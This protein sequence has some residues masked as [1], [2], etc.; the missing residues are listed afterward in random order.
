MSNNIDASQWTTF[1]KVMYGGF[2]YSSFCLPS[3]FFKIIVAILFPPLGELVNI[4]E[5]TITDSFPFI[6]WASVKKLC[7]Y[8]TL[9]TI[10]YSIVLTTLFYIPGLIYTLS[11]IVK[12]EHNLNY[13]IHGQTIYESTD[14]YGSPIRI[15]K[16]TINGVTYIKEI[17]TNGIRTIFQ[18]TT[19][20]I[21]NAENDSINNISKTGADAIKNLN[22]LGGDIAGGFEKAGE[23][24]SQIGNLF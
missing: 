8:E 24:I 20:D 10:V 13:D 7:T 12:K 22:S 11:N 23:G 15:T 16:T 6:T 18:K 3:D 2:G 1:D 17:T 4:L 5:D 19:T 9:N 14:K 21:T